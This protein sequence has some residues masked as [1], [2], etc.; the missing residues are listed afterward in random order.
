MSTP[1]L[2]LALEKVD[3]LPPTRVTDDTSVLTL[4]T[5]VFEPLLRW[6]RGL[7]RPGLFDRWTYSQD[8]RSWRFFIRKAACF[9][10]G[11]PCLAE[12]VIAFVNDIC[13][14][15]DTFGMKWSYARYLANARLSVGADNSVIVENPEPIA[16][17]LDIFSE[18]FLCRL[19]AS[20]AATIGSGPYRVSNFSPRRSATLERVSGAGP[21]TIVAHEIPS[22]EDRLRL[23][24]DGAVD[25]ALNLER[26]HGPLEFDPTLVWGKALNTLSVIYY[27]N[28]FDG[29]FASPEGRLAI[30]HAVDIEGLIS[31]VLHGLAAPSASIVS[32][33]HLGMDHAGTQLIPYDLDR[34]K[35]LLDQTGAESKVTLR[36]PTFM[37][38]R[39]KEISLFVADQLGD[40]GLSVTV[41]IETDRPEYARQVGRKEIGD[42]A[43]FDSSPQS[44]Y[45][46]L[47][48]KI[49]SAVKAV[50]WQ[51]YDD[52]E[53]EKLIVAANRA[54][55][56]SERAIAYGRCLR[57]LNANPPWLYLFHPIE[58]CA[59]RDGVAGLSLDHK[60][61]LNIG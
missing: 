2:T 61:V 11:A 16:D 31:G 32:P 37:P 50:W 35:A 36:T 9:H 46:I 27:L 26:V 3:F 30:N 41:E 21:Q 18:F 4:K 40:L 25:A 56:S 43:I 39:A 59:S 52:A 60:G 55:E 42:L 10:D 33:F 1:I 19:D 14:A 34:A 58:V 29:L 15:V 23:L 20:G 44:T 38:D 5:L 49:S 54:V 17:I 57:R 12:D 53:T 13:S 51:G 47:N 7:A 6:D 22:A 48:D 8:G 24:K 45:R 28:C